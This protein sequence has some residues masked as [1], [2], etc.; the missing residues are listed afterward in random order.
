M[1]CKVT[2]ESQPL[3]FV[4]VCVSVSVD[5]VIFV[6]SYQS[7]LLQAK[8]VVS[9][10]LL[11]PTV[12]CS[13][14]TESQPLTFVKVWVSVS[15]DSVMPV[16]SYQSKVLQAKAVVSPVLLWPTVRCRVTTESQPNTLVKVWVSVSVD[17]VM[18]VFSYQS[19]LSHAKAVVSPTLAGR[20]VRCSVTVLSQAFTSV[21][22]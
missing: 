6:C 8:A 1:R 21:K 5:S 7:K 14:T 13:V 4:K 20:M 9:P 16:F 3:T 19:K 12:R 15:V 2:T 17:S 10:V 18:F 22:C 11:C